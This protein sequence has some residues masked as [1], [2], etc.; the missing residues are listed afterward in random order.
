MF[1]GYDS[2]GWVRAMWTSEPSALQAQGLDV[3]EVDHPNAPDG[4]N[5][6]VTNGQL[7]ELVGTPEQHQTRRERRRQRRERRRSRGLV[8]R[9]GEGRIPI[10]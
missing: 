6:R 3:L 10:P 5:W 7:V 4:G 1:Y 8:P 9:P 2:D